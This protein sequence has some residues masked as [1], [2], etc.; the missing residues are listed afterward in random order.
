MALVT[1]EIRG[2]DLPGRNCGPEPGG[3]THED[4]HVGLARRTETVELTPGDAASVRWEFEVEVS[5]GDDG[6]FDFR[7]PFVGGRRGERSL[8]LRWGTFDEDGTFVVFRAAKFRLWELDRELIDEAS[9]TGHLV[10][11]V[12]LTDEQGNPRCATVR[13]PH[14]TWSAVAP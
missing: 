12:G 10:A 9:S 4:I 3:L 14:V 8:G 6:E 11:T 2:T 5:E 7:G 13:P 1:V